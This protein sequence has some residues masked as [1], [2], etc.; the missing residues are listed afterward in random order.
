MKFTMNLDVLYVKGK[1][2]E[3]KTEIG[4]IRVIFLNSHHSDNLFNKLQ[5]LVLKNV[6]KLISET[7]ACTVY[8]HS[9]FGFQPEH[10]CFIFRDSLSNP[11]TRSVNVRLKTK[12]FPFIQTVLLIHKRLRT[13]GPY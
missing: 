4:F 1:T 6:K 5:L 11:Y 12:D 7:Q 10:C 2:V 9:H 13:L 3:T 8:L